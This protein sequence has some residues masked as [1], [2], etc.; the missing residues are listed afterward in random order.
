MQSTDQTTDASA[1][2]LRRSSGC[3][4][5]ENWYFEWGHKNL[6]NC[7]EKA[8][9]VVKH[10][11]SYHFHR[12]GKKSLKWFFQKIL[13][14][15][16]MLSWKEMFRFWWSECDIWNIATTTRLKKA[17]FVEVLPHVFHNVFFRSTSSEMFNPR[18][19]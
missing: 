9:D 1:E 5:F 8:L 13:W 3:E 4:R 6:L 10:T 11:S 17:F 2:E 19:K 18:G 16:N 12:C 15:F 14:F 7:D